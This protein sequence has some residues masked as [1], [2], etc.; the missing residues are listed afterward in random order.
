MCAAN[1]CSQ[2][3]NQTQRQKASNHEYPIT[4][5]AR[6]IAMLNCGTASMP[7]VVTR[8]AQTRLSG[9]SRSAWLHPNHGLHPTRPAAKVRRN[10]ERRS[11]PAC[12]GRVKPNP[13][14]AYM[15]PSELAAVIMSLRASRG[16]SQG[17]LAKRSGLSRNC[18]ALIEAE[19][20]R[21]NSTISTLQSIFN[22]FDL[23]IKFEFRSKSAPNTACSRPAK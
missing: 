23:D 17:E 8:G 19:S 5:S 10:F 2:S 4:L 18:I 9:S 15:K 13:L 16:W 14:D 20:E 11:S 3:A 6:C 7:S 12:A 1:G 21:A 22:A